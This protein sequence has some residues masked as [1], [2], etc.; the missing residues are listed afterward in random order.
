[1][2][3]HVAADREDLCRRCGV[4]CHVAVPVRDGRT[5]VVPHLHCR[6]LAPTVHTDDATPAPGTPG[7]FGCT[8]YSD[9]F[10]QAPWCHTADDAAPQ[11]F[12]ADDCPYG[13]P[14][15][16][17][18]QRLPTGELNRLWPEILRRLRVWGVPA[19]IAPEPFLAEVARREGGRWRLDPWPGGIPGDERL[20][21][22]RSWEQP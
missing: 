10:A 4:S 16:M 9:R 21:L 13:T 7:G 19:Y 18:K 8:V 5:V 2:T 17:G 14:P 6:F 15:G 3:I 1:M 12:L 22:V 11:G 20:R